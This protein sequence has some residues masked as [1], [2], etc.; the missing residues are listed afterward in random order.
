MRFNA[1]A[2]VPATRWRRTLRGAL[3]RRRG[4]EPP[5]AQRVGTTVLPLALWIPYALSWL[6]LDSSSVA[7]AWFV[8][9]IR[10]MS[11]R[12]YRLGLGHG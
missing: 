12:I 5:C 4:F 11:H 1:N 8:F 10:A 6:E 3:N 2:P 9:F 7:L